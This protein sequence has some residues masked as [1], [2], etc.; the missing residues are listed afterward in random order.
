MDID[1]LLTETDPARNVPIPSHDSLAARRLVNQLE[2][3]PP[4][5][6]R[7]K[8]R[9]AR[10]VPTGAAMAAAAAGA[11]IVIAA[12]GGPAAVN[13]GRPSPSFGPATTVAQVMHNAAL[14]ALRMPDRA[15]R[16]DQFVYSKFYTTD[17][18]PRVVQMWTSVSGTRF[19]LVKGG[20]GMPPGGLHTGACVNGRLKAPPP[21]PTVE[22]VPCTQADSAAGY[23]DMP[24]KDPAALKAYLE[25]MFEVHSTSPDDYASQIL[26][27]AGSLN[28]SAYLTPA[29]QAALY[30]LLAQTPGLQLV[31]HVRDQKGDVGLGIRETFSDKGHHYTLVLNAKTYA[32]MGLNFSKDT[33]MVLLTKAIVSNAGQLP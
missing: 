23:P 11:A 15:P 22:P 10:L 25:K 28:L 17:D 3:S 33:G 1:R 19:G 18:G 30:G 2:M 16:P 5:P 21:S 12:T 7:W 9:H 6:Q 8:G 27:L 31:P 24:T 13:A 29:Q 14:A 4:A 20:W 32:L 26:D